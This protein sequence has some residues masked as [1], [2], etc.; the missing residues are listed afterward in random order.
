MHAG[1][2]RPRTKP[3]SAWAR[4]NRQTASQSL[5]PHT[6]ACPPPHAQGPTVRKLAMEVL[7]CDTVEPDAKIDMLIALGVECDSVKAAK[8]Q[9]ADYGQTR[10]KVGGLLGTRKPQAPSGQRMFHG[11]VSLPR[12]RRS[13]VLPAAAGLL[14]D[15]CPT[16][17]SPAAV[18]RVLSHP[19]RPALPAPPA[20]Q[21]V[22][23]VRNMRTK[24]SEKVG[25]HCGHLGCRWGKVQACMHL[26][27]PPPTLPLPTPHPHPHPHP[28]TGHPSGE[29]RAAHLLP[30]AVRRRGH[31]PAR[32][33]RVPGE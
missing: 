9:I 6:T 2:S 8:Q 29:R 33:G 17:E 19:P 22:E 15:T 3:A 16:G 14:P 21:T 13:P 28:H 5:T 32:G 10:V 26:S 23:H 30:R 12:T 25:R 1:W 20:P 7:F 31:H 24:M 18:A 27:S 4:M 11:Q